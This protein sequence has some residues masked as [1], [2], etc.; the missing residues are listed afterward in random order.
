M[1]LP[2]EDP[3]PRITIAMLLL[4]CLSLQAQDK[5]LNLCRNGAFGRAGM[6][7]IWG[8]KIVDSDRSGR[9]LRFED[10]GSASQ[11][12]L[13]GGG[14]RTYT[15]ALDVKVEGVKPQPGKRG[16]AYAAVY[17]TSGRGELVV[18]KDFV[19]PTGTSD[20]ERHSYTFTVDPRA[21]YISLRCGI[22]QAT[23]VAYIDNWTLVRGTEA[24]GIDEVLERGRR[25]TESPGSVAIL[26]APDMPFI[27]APSNPRTIAKI[28]SAAGLKTQLLSAAELADASVLDPSRFDIVVVPTGQAFPADARLTFIEYL[29]N[30]GEFISMGGYAF[31]RLLSRDGKSWRNADVVL[32]EQLDAAMSQEK[33]LLPNGGFEAS[34]SAPVQGLELDAQWRRNSDLSTI[35]TEAPQEGKFCAKVVVPPDAPLGETKFYLDLP[36]K[37]MRM[38]KISGWLKTQ[39]VV[40]AGFAYMAVYQYDKTDTLIKHKDFAHARGATDWARSEFQFAP[41]PGVTRLYVK[42]GIY[43]AHGTAW[44]DDLRLANVTGME[45]K[46]MNTATGKPTD[47][48][49]TSPAQIGAFDADF[50]LKRVRSMHAAPGQFIVPAD[51]ELKHEAKGWAA[52]GVLGYDN[53]RW[54]P[55]LQTYDRYDRPRGAAGSIML[56]YNGFYGGSSWA[57]FGVNNADLFADPDG[58]M[59]K[60]LQRVAKF[61]LRETYLHN[62]KT[63]ECLYRDGEAVKI[64]VVVTNRGVRPQ[65]AFVRIMAGESPLTGSHSA[66]VV[67]EERLTVSPES[68]ETVEATFQPKTFGSDLYKVSALL[69]IDA[70]PVDEMTTG[71]VVERAEVMRS[72]AESRFD[73][74]YFTQGGR[75]MFLFGSD[76]YSYTYRSSHENPFTWAQDHRAARDAG[77][78]VYENLQYN[79][80]KHKL[81]ESDWRA[82][83][84]MAQLTQRHNLVFMPGMLIGHDVGIDEDQVAE[85]SAHCA[86]YAQRLHDV[87]GLHYYINGDYQSRLWKKENNERAVLLWNKWLKQRYGSAAKLKAAWGAEAVT[88]ELGKLPYPPH[89][90]NHWHDRGA[91]DKLRFLTWLTK[92]WNVS[93]VAAVRQ[94][95]TT[96]PIMSEYY[97]QPFNGLDLVLTIDG[98]DVADIGFFARPVHDIDMLPLKIR[99]NDLRAR[100][101]GVCLGEY[102]V[103]THPAWAIEN[104]GRGYHI[105]RT[106]EEQKQLFLTVG[107]YA[108]GLGACKVQNWCLRDSQSRVFP[109]GYFY[110]NQLIPK[111]VAFTH[112]NESMIWRHFSPRYVAPGLTVCL[113]NN[114]RLGNAPTLGTDVAYRAFADLLALHY[115]FNTIDDYHFDA[116]PAA[117]KVLVYPSPFSI[118]DDA[119]AKLLT[120]VQ[121]GGKLLVTGD[122]SYDANRK[123]T[124]RARLHELLGVDFVSTRYD[125]LQRSGAAVECALAGMKAAQLR[126]CITCKLAGGDA[127]AATKDGAPVFVR[128]DVGQG[129]VYWLADPIE[130][131]DGDDG[132]DMRRAIYKAFLDAVG[133]KPLAIAPDVPWLHVM[134][135]PTAHGVLHVL[136]NTKLEEGQADVTVQTKAGAVTVC[137]RNR[138]P[139]LV[140]ATDNGRVVAVNAYGEASVGGKPIVQGTGLKALLS[141]DGHDLRESKAL[142]VGPFETGELV[143]PAR[144]AS[145]MAYVGEFRGGEWTTMERVRMGKMQLTIDADRATGM[146]LICEPDREADWA[147]K[148]SEAMTRP[149]KIAGY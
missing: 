118:N 36:A 125:S 109:W 122:I 128:N 51:V 18:F 82:F 78:N 49:V 22:Y 112:R 114:L 70:E 7:T 77:L 93:H 92:R 64:S 117:T 35:V 91:I 110:P 146:I 120:W 38:Y 39:H 11:N 50:G 21:T 123:P 149:E 15:A 42:V 57:Y 37:P 96:H 140:A 6:W 101:K 129:E 67:H 95:D 65:N 3:M 81:L 4:A 33:S 142:L 32:R 135:Q 68:D 24:K 12:V 148:L 100:G 87:S 138:W 1:L 145:F 41:E 23:G 53:A 52:S 83:R 143:L 55:I 17:Q 26:N 8:G 141:L 46:P 72:A 133:V 10:G 20:W 124:R 59:A 71:F 116:M 76:T 28:F 75:P 104:G 30:G 60:A 48:L 62:L 137:T 136:Y 108:L 45:P 47:G 126:P 40:G 58:P 130:L 147:A 29:R 66:G 134:R 31:R 5:S 61:L 34:Q 27:G 103:K 56:N 94:H 88:A 63:G 132:K 113:A 99:W 105:V 139:A 69:V 9:C 84:A 79:Q 106:E 13:V 111:D 54:I 80:P 119:Y 43:N 98:Q 2:K 16:Y 85:Q 90:S 102:G 115:D 74:N 14:D 86:D 127:L 25:R 89:N 73:G 19:N 44:F 107:S 121:A 131:A 97:S 144:S